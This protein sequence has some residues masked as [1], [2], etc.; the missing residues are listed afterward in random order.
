MIMKTNILDIIERLE[1]LQRWYLDAGCGWNAGVLEQC[2]DSDGEWIRN[3]DIENLIKELKSKYAICQCDTIE[4]ST[5]NEDVGCMVCDK[6]GA[7]WFEQHC[8]KSYVCIKAY[9]YHLQRMVREK[10][11]LKYLKIFLEK[12]NKLN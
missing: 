7:D 6:C 1:K 5:W 3:E 11:P 9:I 10:E 2:V 8:E 4:D 12:W